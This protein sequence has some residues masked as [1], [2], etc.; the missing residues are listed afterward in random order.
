[1]S[2][3]TYAPA[4][5]PNKT[6]HPTPY[7]SYG[8]PYPTACAH[9][10]PNTFH[11]R[12]PYILASGTLSRTTNSLSTLITALETTLGP[13]AVVGVKRGVKPHTHYSDILPIVS[14]AKAANADIL[15]TL[16]G[17]SLTDAAKVVALA[18]AND[19]TTKDAL[20]SL[21]FDSPTSRD[22]L[23]PAT[24]PIVC[25]PTSLSAGE[26]TPLAG[27]TN[28]ETKHKHSFQHPSVGPRLIILSPE[29]ST[30]T[31]LHIW[32]STG[33][34]AMD[35][36][37][38]AMCSTA[39]TAEADA[40]GSKGL[41]QLVPGL[42]AT[43]R[44]PGALEPRMQCLLGARDAIGC[45]LLRVPMGAS[46]GIGH[47]LGPLGVGHGETSCVLLP[48]VMRYNK[49]VN[50]AEQQK[51]LDVLWGLGEDVGAVLHE[52]GLRRAEADLADVLDA[53]FRELGLPRSLKEVGVGRGQLGALAEGSLRDR[54]CGSNP[55][56]LREKGQVL[57]ILEMVV[58]E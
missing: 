43:K 1:M 49:R 25:I 41:R 2:N 9:H 22:P 14:E 20:E 35:H 52:R 32:L 27:A 21:Y 11:A 12:R 10:I 23:L 13:N 39:S 38:E 29:L 7:I 56:P 31:P 36:C 48:A 5:A 6:P 24:V 58:G 40:S 46:H 34:R 16:G 8:D 15:V 57:E 54:Y 3:E 55:V 47:Q 53:L 51:V 18:L 17:G 44:E 45:G 50:A 28:D 30:T 33:V 42:L 37:V 26:Y 19:A 4:F